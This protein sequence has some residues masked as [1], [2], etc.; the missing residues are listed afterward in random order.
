MANRSINDKS[1]TFPVLDSIFFNDWWQL[2]EWGVQ[3]LDVVPPV[4]TLP[5]FLLNI[6]Q[7]KVCLFI[8][9]FLHFYLTFLNFPSQTSTY[10]SQY[11][12]RKGGTLPELAFVFL[13]LSGLLWDKS[14]K[15]VF[16]KLVLAPADIIIHVLV[17]SLNKLQNNSW[18][19]STG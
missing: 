2:G 16:F 14:F 11:C 17:I 15:L 5:E 13:F 10:F 18:K 7:G 6:H 9:K 1:L 19:L 12:Q 4:S 8:I 3:I